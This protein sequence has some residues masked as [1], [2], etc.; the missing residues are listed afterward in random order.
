MMYD[1]DPDEVDFGDPRDEFGD[2]HF[3]EPGGRSALR[4]ASASNPRNLP[5]P[6]CGEPNRLT[7]ADKRKGY[8]CDACADLAE[9]GGY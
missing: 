1:Y 8:Q 9:G 6:T 5:C 2:D 4:A 7:P 3:A